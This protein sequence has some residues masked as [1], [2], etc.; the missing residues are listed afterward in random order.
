MAAHAAHPLITEDTGT[1]GRGRWQ[2]ELNGER[3]R[4]GAARATQT[5]AVLSYGFVDS[6]DLQVGIPYVR[7][8]GKG[9]AAVDVKW[10]FWESGALSLGLKPGITLP[11]GRDERG[12]GA[13][14]V[15][16]GS[17]FILSYEPERWAFHSHAGYRHNRNTL[18]QRE[19]LKHLSG[20][21]LFKATERLR[22]LIDVSR[23]TDPDPASDTTLRQH[24]VGFIYSLTRDFDIDAGIRRGN[25]PA[26]DRALLFGLTL[27]W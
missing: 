12:L 6:A 1:Q 17:L 2:L 24:V 9:D 21:V 23:D 25:E 4:D 14:R 26:I 18:G 7:H 3:T 15:T 5:A 27:R 19:S 16:W 22:L 20:A 10:R 13:G 11:T 8:E